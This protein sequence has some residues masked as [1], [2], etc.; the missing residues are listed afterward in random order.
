M[1]RVW[2][3]FDPRRVLVALFAFL[4]VAG[5]ADPFHP[6][7]HPAFQLAR[8]RCRTCTPPAQMSALPA[9][10]RRTETAISAGGGFIPP[11]AKSAAAL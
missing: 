2:L 1:Y 3:L 6:A 4:F 11:P 5:S 9:P 8:K 7:Q 10:K